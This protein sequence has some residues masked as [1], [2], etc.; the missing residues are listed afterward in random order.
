[1]GPHSRVTIGQSYATVAGGYGVSGWS[2]S[3][4]YAAPCKA[5]A[6]GS[7]PAGR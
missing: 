7:R 2:M 6:L 5:C 4:L 3:R 1:M